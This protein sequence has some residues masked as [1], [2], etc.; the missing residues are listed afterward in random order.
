MLESVNLFNEAQNLQDAL[1]GIYIYEDMEI[2]GSPFRN[3]RLAK[4]ITQNK[5]AWSYDSR[6]V[7]KK[8]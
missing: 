4:I 3:K 5:S 2:S 6:N 7:P 1:Q 8:R